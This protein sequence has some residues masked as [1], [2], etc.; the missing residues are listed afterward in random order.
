[1]QCLYVWWARWAQF[2]QCC[3]LLAVFLSLTADVL[4]QAMSTNWLRE[5]FS[6]HSWRNLLLAT[7]RLTCAVV[8]FCLA[9]VFAFSSFSEAVFTCSSA[10]KYLL[11]SRHSSLPRTTTN[12]LFESRVSTQLK[13]SSK[14]AEWRRRWRRQG[15]RNWPELGSPVLSI[16]CLSFLSASPHLTYYLCVLNCNRSAFVGATHLCSSCFYNLSWTLN[17]AV[18]KGDLSFFETVHVVRLLSFH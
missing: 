6:R 3:L 4:L 7:L 2:L 1:M 8:G 9:V 17:R 10:S 5:F 15:E 11:W 13:T 12:N 16:R 14:N 18:G